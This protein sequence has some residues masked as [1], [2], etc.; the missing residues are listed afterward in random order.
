MFLCVNNC[1]L[2]VITCPAPKVGMA[3]PYPKLGES[4]MF[5]NDP[6]LCRLRHA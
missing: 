3:C 2:L 1:F 6:S 4:R 5:D